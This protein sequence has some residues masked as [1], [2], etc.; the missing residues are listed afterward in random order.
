M[1]DVTQKMIDKAIRDCIWRKEIHG[2]DICVGMANP[3]L[4]V[5]DRGE[6]DT[7]KKLFS[8]AKMKG[9]DDE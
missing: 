8:G 2:T 1:S 9:G 7:L 5:I 4:R 6:C 3:C